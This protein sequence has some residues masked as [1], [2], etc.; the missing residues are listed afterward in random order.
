MW[1]EPPPPPA[2]TAPEPDISKEID[3]IRRD[4]AEIRGERDRAWI[5]ETRRMEIERV[6]ADMIADSDDRS[7]GSGRP[8]YEI[9]SPDG[10]FTM[11]IDFYM[12]STWAFNRTLDQT[13]EKGFEIETVRLTFQGTI[14]DPTWSYQTRLTYLSDTPGFMQFAIIQKDLG[15]GAFVQMGL[16]EPLFTL[17]EAIDNNQQLGVYLSFLA[18]QWDC[19]SIPGVS[20]G[21]SSDDLRGWVSLTDAWGGEQNTFYR[22]QR[23]VIIARGEW[24]PYG[25]W[26]DLYDFNAYPEST[27]PGMLVGFGASHGWGTTAIGTPEEYTGA[28][29]R[30]TADVSLQRPGLGGMATISWQS[31]VPLEP[32]DGG[33][34]RLAVV[35]QMGWFVDPQIVL[36]ARG[37]WGRAMNIDVEPNELALMTCGFSWMPRSNRQI[38]FSAEFVQT[39]GDARYWAIDGD[40]GIRQ[41]DERQ[42]IVRAQLQLSF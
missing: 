37:E 39:W 22:N 35:S 32:L 38:K 20:L 5:D 24:K 1:T 3:S 15:D 16:L 19:Q 25:D 34:D 41:V 23:Q 13:T 30:L 33:G 40:P 12:Q 29:T 7:F 6:V 28:D 14:I 9:A 17:E 31:N 42:S 27:I 11:G 26:N 10:S 36:Y 21:W 18:G 4:L 8:W 2:H